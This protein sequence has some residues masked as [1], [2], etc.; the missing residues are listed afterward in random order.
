MKGKKKDIGTEQIYTDITGEVFMTNRAVDDTVILRQIAYNIAHLADE[1]RTLRR[2][3]IGFSDDAVEEDTEE[4]KEESK[5]ESGEDKEESDK[6]ETCFICGRKLHIRDAAGV[7]IN[8]GDIS[9]CCKNCSDKFD[10]LVD[11]FVM[12]NSVFF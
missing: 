5:E 12:P 7:I 11:V 10:K 8:G 3:L 2:D 4:T 9:C 1:V 6:R